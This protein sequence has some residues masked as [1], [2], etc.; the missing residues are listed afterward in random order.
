MNNIEV[1]NESE[2]GTHVDKQKKPADF[3]FSP[4]AEASMNVAALQTALNGGG[5]ISID[6]PGVYDLNDTVFLDSNTKLICAPGVIFRK[7]A[8]YCNVFLNR[9]AL[10]KEYNDNISIDGLELSVNGQEAKPTLVRGQRAQLGFFYVRNLKIRNFTCS[11]GESFQFLIYIV[12]WKNILIENV[13]LAGEKD[14]IK[15][16]NGHEAIIRNLDLTTYDDGLSLCGTDYD[17]VTLEVGDVYNVYCSNITDHQYQLKGK[18]IFGRTCL[19]YTGSW[20]DYKKGNKYGNSDF[21]LNDGKLYQHV[22]EPGNPIAVSSEAPLHNEGTVTG[23]DGIPWR[24]I[25]PCDFYQTNVYNVSFDSCIFEKG[26]NIIANWICP[27]NM[28][29]ETP[30]HRTSYPGTEG[31]SDSWGISITNCK[32]VG[33]PPQILL[34]L[35]GNMQNVAISG[36]YFNNP[37]STMINVDHYSSNKELIATINACTFI[38]M[39]PPSDVLH[40]DNEASL[41]DHQECPILKRDIDATGYLVVVDNGSKV[42]CSASG[43]ACRGAKLKCFVSDDSELRFSSTDLPLMN[44]EDKSCCDSDSL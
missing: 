22:L 14:G 20:A 29:E 1:M 42:S 43:N 16:N 23:R 9:G 32:I 34:N 31:N 27:S 21:C 18:D 26:G 11:D 37:R 6:L 40:N 25:Q 19:I 10:T 8:P 28:Y 41:L 3:G 44:I 36:C 17:S 24:F 33:T 38:D 35:M 15:L 5:V 2:A 4:S 7:V 13:R 12:T 30:I 39:N